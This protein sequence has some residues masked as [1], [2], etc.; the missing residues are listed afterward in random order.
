MGTA[1]RSQT[2]RR[3]R[4]ASRQCRPPADADFQQIK[5]VAFGVVHPFGTA[6]G[7]LSALE[8]GE[9]SIATPEIGFEHLRADE[10]ETSQPAGLGAAESDGA[11][12][13]GLQ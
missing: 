9:N 2:D 5:R 1:A 10:L 8:H 12:F 11:G 4:R 7:P 3:I 6:V 13:E